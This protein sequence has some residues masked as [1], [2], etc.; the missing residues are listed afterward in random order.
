ME[1][2]ELKSEPLVE[3]PIAEETKDTSQ[4]KKKKK[5]RNKKKKPAEPS[6][7]QPTNSIPNPPVKSSQMSPSFFNKFQDNSHL[8]RVKNWNEDPTYKQTNPPSVPLSQQFAQGNFPHGEEVNYTS[9]ITSQEH[10]ERERI[11]NY[12]YD[13]MRKAAECHRQIR[14]WAQGVLKPGVELHDFVEEL[15]NYSRTLLEA[16]GIE[17]GVGFPTGVS[18]NFCAAHYTPNPGDKVY[19][20]EDDLCKLDFGTHIGGRIID[21][22]FTVAFNPK[23]DNLIQASQEATNTGLREA[24]IDARFSEIGAAIQEA[25]ESFEVELDGKVYKVKS[26]R[27][28]NGH[29]IGPYHIHAGKSVPITKNNDPGRMEEGEV[30][31]IE[32]FGSTG[33]GVVHD[34]MECSH[35]MI[36]FDMFQ[37][38]VPIRDPKAR[39]L[40]KH[41]EK[42]YGT[43]P[44]SRRQ[45]TRD[46]EIK[47]L[48]P[49]KSLINSG[50]VVPYPP[51][52]DVRGSFVSQ[53]EHTVLLRPTCKEIISRGDDF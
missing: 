53:M 20:T 48:M 10:R 17:G 42:K 6:I 8:R 9:R 39:A 25:M 21:C 37:K 47:H 26:I 3:K 31:A 29:L 1:T 22:A 51:L 15:E 28:L 40:L 46:G 38:P 35:H 24:G 13:A 50:I 18:L 33:K 52:C 4:A 14:R 27:N 41:I 16:D 43:L 36:D 44:W 49:L 23:F 7:A 5:K 12:D 30:Y 34:D 45:L 11:S 32:T 19:L 2:E